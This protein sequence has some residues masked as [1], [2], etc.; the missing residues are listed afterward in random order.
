MTQV[1]K[2]QIRDLSHEIWAAAQLLPN[3]G[4]EDGADRIASIL[5]PALDAGG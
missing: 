5:Q 2:D 1:T 3:E 4:I